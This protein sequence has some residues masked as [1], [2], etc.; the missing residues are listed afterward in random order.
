MSLASLDMTL[1]LSFEAVYQSK[2]V[3]VAAQRLGVRQP[4]VSAALARLRVLFG[5][6]LFVRAAG[7]MR[8]T[9]KALR[10]APG[11]TAALT[12]LR[13]TVADAVPFSPADAK[14]TFTIASNDYASL[15]LV[16]G[17]VAA[18]TAEA[19]NVDLRVIGYDKDD[20]P[21]LIDRGEIDLAL[22]VFQTPPDRAVRQILYRERFV[23]IARA[24]HPM[25]ARG[26]VSL[27]AYAG[28]DHAL[29]TLRRDA[30]GEIDGAL[31]QRGLSRRVALTLPH[32]LA[33]PGA[34]LAG[35]L[36]AAI[37]ARAAAILARD[38]LSLFEIPLNLP[39]W[40]LEMLWNPGARSERA[41]AWFRATVAAV[42]RSV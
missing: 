28:A 2:S 40:T 42:A 14:R 17:L 27:E 19:P 30:V 4:T 7:E 22:G 12:R 36:V 18:L 15:V 20:V 10:I 35:D 38:G 32:L 25:L 39:A 21:G 24:S 3:S 23:G 13:E 37:P 34:L 11:I 29:V 8:P 6:E 41:S 1:L 33:L 26:P 31:R 16:P 5:D 9:P